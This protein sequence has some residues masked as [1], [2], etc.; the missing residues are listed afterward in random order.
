LTTTG[1]VER[2]PDG[3]IKVWSKRFKQPCFG[4]DFWI[5]KKRVRRTGFPTLTDARIAAL[6]LRQKELQLNSQAP[7]EALLTEISSLSW[8]QREKSLKFKTPAVGAMS[9][10]IVC[11]DLLRQGYDVYRSV[12]PVG[13]CDIIV[14]KDRR[15]CRVEVKTA[16]RAPSGRAQ[17]NEDACNPESYDVLALVFLEESLI[18]YRPNVEEWFENYNAQAKIA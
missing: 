5:G 17:Y 3:L 18:E 7:V 10:L 9:E 4:Y 12:A 2:Y 11:A 15:L 6:K 14:L 8:H 1:I 16:R 13:A